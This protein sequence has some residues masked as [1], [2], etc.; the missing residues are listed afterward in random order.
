MGRD[1]IDIFMDDDSADLKAFMLEALGIDEDDFDNDERILTKEHIED[2]WDI[3]TKMVEVRSH[4][5]SSFFVL[6]YFV[7]ITGAGIPDDWKEL[8]L[9]RTH[10]KHELGVYKPNFELCRQI[11]IHDFR[12]KLKRHERGKRLHPMQWAYNK[13]LHE[14]LLVGVEQVKYRANHLDP[15]KI[16]HINLDGWALEEIPEEVFDFENLKTLRIG[17]NNLSSIPENITKL[18]RLEHL[19]VNYNK[20]KSIPDYIGKINSLKSL[21]F[22]NNEIS[23]L[24]DALLSLKNLEYIL[25]RKNKIRQ[26]PESLRPA[27]FGIE[28][29]HLD[30]PSEHVYD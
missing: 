8:I 11:Y 16:R 15:S 7:L 18:K 2:H 17:Y 19:R 12:E 14:G 28:Y 23:A 29:I 9:E 1:D 6:G 30:E 20:L 10:W 22:D 13:R 5:N 27:R 21:D 26:I 4:R 24:P 3:L 25:V